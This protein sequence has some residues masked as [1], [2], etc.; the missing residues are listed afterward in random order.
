MCIATQKKVKLLKYVLNESSISLSQNA[1]KEF[2]LAFNSDI[3]KEIL[4][5]NKD[6]KSAKIY[7]NLEGL[8]KLRFE[9]PDTNSTYYLVKKDI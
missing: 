5:C 9:S 4:A 8:M 1:S 7:L 3:L 2:E 6:A